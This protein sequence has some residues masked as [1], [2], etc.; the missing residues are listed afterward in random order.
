MK[1]SVP[2]VSKFQRRLRNE[3]EWRARLAE[4][5]VCIL[6]LFFLLFFFLNRLTQLNRL[7]HAWELLDL[8]A[9]WELH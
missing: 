1:N 9:A 7:V 4:I 2:D 3:A 5:L 8:G 6:F